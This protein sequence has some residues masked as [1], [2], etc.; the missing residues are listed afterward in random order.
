MRTKTYNV[1][2]AVCISLKLMSRFSKRYGAFCLISRLSFSSLKAFS[3]SLPLICKY[4]SNSTES[5][6][7][8]LIN[9]KIMSNETSLHITE[10]LWKVRFIVYSSHKF[11]KF[12]RVPHVTLFSWVTHY[13]YPYKSTTIAT[14]NWLTF[15]TNV[16]IDNFS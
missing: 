6:M 7:V 5:V 12:I 15:L 4:L 11:F 13:F 2:Q 14:N 3:T 1:V 16:S 8:T 10:C 9:C